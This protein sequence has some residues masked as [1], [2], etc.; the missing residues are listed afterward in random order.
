MLARL[1]RKMNLPPKE[2]R[3]YRLREVRKR[4][5]KLAIKARNQLMKPVFKA[6]NWLASAAPS[7]IGVGCV[8]YR[9]LPLP[10]AHIRQ[11]TAQFRDDAVFLD[12]ATREAKRLQDLCSLDASSRVLDVGCGSGRLPIGLLNAVGSLD[13]Y[14]GIDVYR[15]SIDWCKRYIG[16][17][18]PGARFIH[19]DVQNELYNKEGKQIDD[20]FR[21]PVDDGSFDVIYLC[22][23]FSHME[24][25]DVVNYLNEFNRLLSPKG[26]VSL[27]A[28]VEDNVPDIEVNPDGYIHEWSGPLHCVRYDREFVNQLV[29]GSGLCIDRFD[30]A[31]PNHDGQSEIILRRKVSS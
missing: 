19:I 27:T 14:C 6:R 17:A 22:S 13:G 11:G 16:R 12:T 18:N 29:D 2:I 31:A 30:H 5:K 21:L 28:Y 15:P 25:N 10:P 3:G 26:C 23:V 8:N 20:S 4:R 9:G 7:L 24:T 1:L